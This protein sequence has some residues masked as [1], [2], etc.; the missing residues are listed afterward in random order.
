MGKIGL[1]TIGA[2]HKIALLSIGLIFCSGAR[3]SWSAL[4]PQT[5]RLGVRHVCRHGP[6]GFSHSAWTISGLMHCSKLRLVFGDLIRP[7]LRGLIR[8][9]GAFRSPSVNS[10]RFG[11]P[12]PRAS[13]ADIVKAGSHDI[14]RQNVLLRGVSRDALA[15]R[16]RARQRFGRFRQRSR[17]ATINSPISLTTTS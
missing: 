12:A 7:K 16:R 4:P 10:C 11:S 6:G 15:P 17:W 9:T 1:K 14:S 13:H 3:V 5:R 8:A 2:T